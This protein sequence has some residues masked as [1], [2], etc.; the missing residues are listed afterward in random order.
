MRSR[1]RAEGAP[2][3]AP[4]HSPASG[5]LSPLKLFPPKGNPAPW[6]TFSEGRQRTDKGARGLPPA[7]TGGHPRKMS[8]I[9][10]LH[11]LMES[12]RF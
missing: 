5:R 3:N 8:L 12:C 6:A 7:H 1:R 10:A 11:I 4:T 9:S 2:S